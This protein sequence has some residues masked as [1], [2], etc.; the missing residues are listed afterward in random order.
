MASIVAMGGLPWVVLPVSGV[1]TLIG[2]AVCEWQRR[3]T[4]VAVLRQ[5]PHGTVVVQEPGIAGPGVRIHIGDPG[6][7]ATEGG[8]PCR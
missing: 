8:E 7:R 2:M 3:R 6:K 1:L 5:A 4:L